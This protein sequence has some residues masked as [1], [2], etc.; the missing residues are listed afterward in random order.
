MM[1][2]SQNE[3]LLLTPSSEKELQRQGHKPLEM[4]QR[5]VG[6]PSLQGNR[7]F[8]P[9]ADVCLRQGDEKRP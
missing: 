2:Q 5:Q 1:K 8:G 6:K 4:Q 9:E 3:L 7:T